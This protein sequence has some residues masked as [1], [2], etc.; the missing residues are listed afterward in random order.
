MQGLLASSIPFSPVSTTKS[1]NAPSYQRQ[2]DDIRSKIA[3]TQSDYDSLVSQINVQ[4]TLI[5]NKRNEIE[6]FRS[7]TN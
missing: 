1:I 3:S 5:A 2:S 4:D 6:R 7:Q